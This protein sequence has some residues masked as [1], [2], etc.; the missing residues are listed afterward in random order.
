MTAGLRLA[1]MVIVMACG[2]RGAT[3][4]LTQADA[5]HSA[6]ASAGAIRT[7]ESV[8]ALSGTLPDGALWRARVPGG[9]NGTL[10]LYSHGYLPDVRPPNLA[11]AGLESWLL[12]NG[13]ALAAS[14]YAHGGWAVADAIPD[15]L[16]TL[17]VFAARVATPRRTIAWGES[18]GGL[19][20]IALAERADA[21]ID[22]A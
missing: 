11:P 1:V 20:T 19:V 13:Y 9:W 4:A 22:G 21:P 16:G 17:A 8:T 7:L 6:T 2:A 5:R 10:I 3:P 18:M 12:Q 15:Q 14:S